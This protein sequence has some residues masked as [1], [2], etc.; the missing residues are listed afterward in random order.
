MYITAA[1]YF[2]KQPKFIYLHG[3]D[4]YISAGRHTGLD[5]SSGIRIV[6]SIH[7]IYAPDNQD[8]SSGSHIL[9][10]NHYIYA[11]DNQLVESFL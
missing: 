9:S 8:I 5:I 1:V 7:Y 4:H 11:H 2:Q 10:G 6:S 3:T